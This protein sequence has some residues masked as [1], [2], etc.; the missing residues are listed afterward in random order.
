M[1]RS[2][3]PVVAAVLLAGCNCEWFQCENV[4]D[5][6]GDW[7][8]SAEVADGLWEA[9][10]EKDQKEPTGQMLPDTTEAPT[11]EAPPDT[12]PLYWNSNRV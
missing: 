12:V 5:I 8:T 9:E 7:D 6:E 11:G 2:L 10:R 1:I 4:P 3:L